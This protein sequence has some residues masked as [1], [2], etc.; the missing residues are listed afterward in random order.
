MRLLRNLVNNH[1]T[2]IIIEHN[3]ELI[4]R[5]DWIIDLGPN[6]GNKGGQIVFQGTPEKLIECPDSQTAKYLKLAIQ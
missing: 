3:L 4:G 2:V 1:N 5:A 6:S